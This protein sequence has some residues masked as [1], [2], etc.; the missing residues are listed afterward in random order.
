MEIY[1]DTKRIFVDNP[2]DVLAKATGGSQFFFVKQKGLEEAVQRI[3]QQIRS[4]YL[5]TYQPNNA[6][7]PGFHQ[8]AVTVDN[9]RYIAK[10][11]PGYWI[12][13]GKQ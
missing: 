12:G 1:R 9:P 10:T 11:R 3:S 5:I 13:G 8:L 6:G 2:S 4:Q 7:E